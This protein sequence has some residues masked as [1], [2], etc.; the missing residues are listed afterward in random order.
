[1]SSVFQLISFHRKA[2]AEMNACEGDVPD[3]LIFVEGKARA[4]LFDEPP[5]TVEEIRDA[6]QYIAAYAEHDGGWA[7]AGE[8][9]PTLLRSPVLM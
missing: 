2:V 4:A 6:V 7:R 9:L 5:Q 8:Y 3:A 1:M